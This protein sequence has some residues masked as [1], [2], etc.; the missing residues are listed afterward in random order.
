MVVVL[1]V[2]SLVPLAA[3]Q[4]DPIDTIVRDE[5]T[6]DGERPGVVLPGQR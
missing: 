4:S 6:P 3:R 1:L 2:M 5:M